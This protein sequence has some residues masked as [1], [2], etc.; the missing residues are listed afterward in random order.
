MRE[1]ERGPLR[2]MR[3]ATP[4]SRRWASRHFVVGLVRDR[5]GGDAV[6]RL[7]WAIEKLR[8]GADRDAV[9]AAEREQI[10][11]PTDDDTRAAADSE[12][13]HHIVFGVARHLELHGDRGQGSYSGEQ[14]DK[15]QALG[16]TGV[17]VELW[18]LQH[19]IQF[20]EQRQRDQE[21]ALVKGEINGVSRRRGRKQEG[22]D[23][24]VGVE[25]NAHLGPERHTRSSV[26]RAS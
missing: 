23:E 14:V 17:L 19:A 13:K 3:P 4:G 20:A 24:H 5:L 16:G 22:A 9:I 6:S 26:A 15:L 2:T 11:I 8:R 10:A 12:L 21:F 18:I 25:D 7:V 1:D